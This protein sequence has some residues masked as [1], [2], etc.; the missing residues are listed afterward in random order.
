MFYL[1]DAIEDERRA[2]Y[3]ACGDEPTTRQLGVR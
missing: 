1:N 3:I 2:Q